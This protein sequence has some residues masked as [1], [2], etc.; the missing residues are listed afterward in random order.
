MYQYN[1]SDN[2]SMQDNNTSA[3]NCRT[4]TSNK[5]VFSKHSYGIAI[6]INPLINP[7]IKKGKVLPPAG[8]QYIERKSGV[9]GLIL[10]GGI[11]Y[12]AF[13]N[14]GWK[15]GGDWH[16]L[17][18]YQH[19][20]KKLSVF[21]R[22]KKYSLEFKNLPDKSKVKIMNIRAAYQKGKFLGRGLYD[23]KIITNDQVKRFW[24]AIEKDTVIDYLDNQ[25][26]K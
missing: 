7:Y 4:T 24:L 1:A 12:T 18:D 13:K 8:K 3:F 25:L 14:K 11:C 21:K 15:W 5:K 2:D 16:S 10:K 17:K 26:E 6:D 20:E 22:E 9:K 23:I 19:F